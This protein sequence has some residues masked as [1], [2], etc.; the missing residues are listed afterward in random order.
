MRLPRGILRS[1]LQIHHGGLTS[2]GLNAER[3]CRKSDIVND[4]EV[5]PAV[6]GLGNL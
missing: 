5:D 3:G 1:L 6:P 2:T 4:T